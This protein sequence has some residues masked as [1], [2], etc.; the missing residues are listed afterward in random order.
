M[1][2]QAR[3]WTSALDWPEGQRDLNN[4]L[5]SR[6]RQARKKCLVHNKAI[7]NIFQ[8]FGNILAKQLQR[9]A[10]LPAIVTWNQYRIISLQMRWQRFAAVL[11][12]F[13]FVWI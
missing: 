1:S 8:L 5:V 6:T 4:P 9:P 12:L 3:S 7:R 2:Q 13:L 11:A 10:T